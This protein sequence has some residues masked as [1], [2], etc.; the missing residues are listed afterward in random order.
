MEITIQKILEDYWSQILLLLTAIGILLR[1]VLT[2]FLK[3]KEINHGVIHKNRMDALI[4][5]FNAFAELKS[6]WVKLPIFQIFRNEITSNEIDGQIQPPL[7]NLEASII[8]L[9]IYFDGELYDKFKSIENNMFKMNRKFL[10]IAHE[11]DQN[12]TLTNKTN[13]YIIFRQ[14]IEKKNA[15]ILKEISRKLSKKYK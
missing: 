15:D 7:N 4:R 9:Q 2:F 13:D 6:M 3:K 1:M 11:V 14:D 5:F 10:N 12:R 8:E